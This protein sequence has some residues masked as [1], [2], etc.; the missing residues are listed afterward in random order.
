MAGQV[1]DRIIA[2]S[3]RDRHSGAHRRFAAPADA[4]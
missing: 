3:T 4:L 2:R 1:L